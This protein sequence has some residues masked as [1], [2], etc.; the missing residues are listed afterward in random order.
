ML[1]KVPGT[2]RGDRKDMENEGISGNPS[3]LGTV[4]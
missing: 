1:K 2:E 3:T 4:F